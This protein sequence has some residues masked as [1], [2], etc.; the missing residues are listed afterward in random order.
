M[1]F[2][3]GASSVELSGGIARG[4]RDCFTLGAHAG[5]TLVVTQ[6]VHGDGNI[7]L[8]LYRPPWTI[9]QGAGAVE[10]AGVPL[11][12]AEDGADAHNWHGR[13]PVSGAY[14]LV[15][16]ATRGGGDYRIKVEIN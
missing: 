4:D 13:L 2:A 15:I 11:Q 6:P 9:A 5:Q 8:Q 16:G 1:R 3:P 14:L 10:F 12:G 7:V